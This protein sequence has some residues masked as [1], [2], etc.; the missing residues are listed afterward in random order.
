M[1]PV[2]SV[3]F[4]LWSSRKFCHTSCLALFLAARYLSISICEMYFPVF[5]L[6]ITCRRVC[7]LVSTADL[8]IWLNLDL[9]REEIC[10]LGVDLLIA[11]MRV[12]IIDFVKIST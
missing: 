3:T 4:F 5:R 8:Q 2:A 7:S 11:V 12:S 6:L 1:S 10:S 9:A